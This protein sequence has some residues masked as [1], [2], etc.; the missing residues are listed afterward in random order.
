MR[1]DRTEHCNLAFAAYLES[2][3]KS[4]MDWSLGVNAGGNL[5]KDMLLKDAPEGWLSHTLRIVDMFSCDRLSIYVDPANVL[6]SLV[7]QGL[8]PC[9]PL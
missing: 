5:G 7:A 9:S 2:M 4:Y 1:F 6:A 8:Y 3:T